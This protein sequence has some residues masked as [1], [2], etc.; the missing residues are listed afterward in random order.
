MK[1]IHIFKPLIFTIPLIFMG[2]GQQ[3]TAV[4]APA[5][6]NVKNN[7]NIIIKVEK[8]GEKL[9]TSVD[10]Y[11]LVIPKPTRPGQRKGEQTR[12]FVCLE[13]DAVFSGQ[14]IAWDSTGPNAPPAGEFGVADKPNGNPRKGPKFIVLTN[15]NSNPPGIYNYIAIVTVDGTNIQLSIDPRVDNKGGGY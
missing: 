10:P 5:P 15:K 12:I 9:T 2:C 4:A 6:C 1:K 8:N 3:P 13:G 7:F 14:S 11:T